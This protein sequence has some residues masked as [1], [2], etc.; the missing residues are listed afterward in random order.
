MGVRSPVVVLFLLLAGACLYFFEFASLT[1][2]SV[3]IFFAGLFMGGPAN[4]ISGTIAA[5]LGTHES[6]KGR[7][8]ALATVNF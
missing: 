6:I 3:L 4:L 1:L 8:D 2:V 7:A 5:D